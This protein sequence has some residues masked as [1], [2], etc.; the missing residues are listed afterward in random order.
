LAFKPPKL[1][2]T[3]RAIRDGLDGAV[4]K[5]LVNVPTSLEDTVA[6]ADLARIRSLAVGRAAA[7]KA[8]LM[9]SSMA[10]PPG[11]LGWL[12]LL[13]ELVAVWR[14]Q[15]QMVADIAAIHGKS[16]SLNREHLLYCLFKHVSAQVLR[17]VVVRTGE[18]FLVQKA[19]SAVLQTI[20]KKLGVKLSQQLAGKGAARFIPLVGAVG[21]GAYAYFDTTQVAK[22]AIEF[23]SSEFDDI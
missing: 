3:G 21:M 17:D 2:S 10:L 18:R 14:V 20:A 23:F 4:L 13:P 6:N 15:S 12:T 16:G 1:A 8:T 9:A 22:T 19:S 11:V 5:L 7:R